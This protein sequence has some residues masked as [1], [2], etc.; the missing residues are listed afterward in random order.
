MN[1]LLDHHATLGNLSG[2]TSGT[3]VQPPKVQDGVGSWKARVW[4]GGGQ[5]EGLIWD[6]TVDLGLGASDVG[7]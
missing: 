5:G 6:E 2:E 1:W 3:W 7:C 4:L